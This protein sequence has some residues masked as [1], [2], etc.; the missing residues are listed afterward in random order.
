MH[1]ARACQPCDFAHQAAPSRA[2][3]P[4][5]EPDNERLLSRSLRRQET[6]QGRT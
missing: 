5:A 6:G 4:A 3:A 1:Q 2:P